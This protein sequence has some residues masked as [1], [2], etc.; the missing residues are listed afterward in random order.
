MKYLC[1]CYYDTEAL[2]KL[3][4]SEMYETYGAKK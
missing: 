2:A 3:S 4:P 1:L